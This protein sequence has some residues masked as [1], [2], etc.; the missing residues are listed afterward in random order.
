MNG[1]FCNPR[2]LSEN[3]VTQFHSIPEIF[4]ATASIDNV[5]S[6]LPAIS[7]FYQFHFMSILTILVD[8]NSSWIH[9]KVLNLLFNQ[10]ALS[11][12]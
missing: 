1:Y 5:I 10:L 11:S 3:V 12:H 2:V 9:I 7:V 4:M 6:L 8:I